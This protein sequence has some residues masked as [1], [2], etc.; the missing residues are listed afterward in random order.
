MI[1]RC[2]IALMSLASL[3]TAATARDSPPPIGVQRNVVFADYS[4]LSSST[5][6]MGRLLSPLNAMRVQ[7][8]LARSA[9]PLIAQSIDLTRERFAVHVPPEAPPPSGYALMVFVPPWEEAIVP[10]QWVPMLDRNHLIYVSAAN[11]G[12]TEDVLDRRE[13]LALLSE[14]NM[15]K[16]YRVD[17]R[18]IY[19]GGF[20]GGSRIALRLAL[21]YPDVFRGALLDAGSDPIGTMKIPLPPAGLMRQF[22][23]SSRV[24]YLT[25]ADD[26]IRLDQ[27]QA[28]RQSLHD[29]CVFDVDILTAP[30]TGH[31]LADAKI[32]E[33]A[34]RALEQP[35]Q[36]NATKL[37]ECRAD[38]GRKLS[39]QLQ[40][41]QSLLSVGKADDARKLLK[42]IDAHYGGLAAPRSIE[43]MEKLAA[44]NVTTVRVN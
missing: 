38:I 6:I 42:H 4:P 21:A 17:P 24:V 30:S 18:R 28:S 10:V 43:L 7:Q 5:E 12:N 40:H 8:A 36:H 39:A 9:R 2:L 20:S 11:S 16:R 41:A 14:Y 31:E 29:W 1:I 19:I 33:R 13:P 34:L 15:V 25:G 35:A 37:A 23:D 22:Q 3:L 26:T 27:G 44:A 32:L